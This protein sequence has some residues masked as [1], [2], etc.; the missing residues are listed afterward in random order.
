M[1][2]KSRRTKTET[3]GPRGTRTA[4]AR[5]S[6]FLAKYEPDIAAVAKKA[7]AKLRARLAGAVELV[8]DNYNALV[9]GFGPNERAADAIFSLVLYPR[10][11]SLFFL[12][13]ATLADPRRLLRGT[14]VRVRHM[15][16]QS[17]D[18]LDEPA[19]QDL[20]GRALMEARTPLAETAPR[21][22]IIKSVSTRQRPR[23]PKP[24]SGRRR[25]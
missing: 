24:T 1:N 22:L 17:A 5:L 7:R 20:I 21:R 25:K 19:V 15:V 18:D 11:V 2:A 3:E 12:Q 8:Y 9:I 14:G 16:L 23:R 6:S 10:W 4:A 13:G